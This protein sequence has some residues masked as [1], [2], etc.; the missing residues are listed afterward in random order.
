M[1]SEEEDTQYQI[2]D[3]DNL[4]D[5]PPEYDDYIQ[6]TLNVPPFPHRLYLNTRHPLT[7][8]INNETLCISYVLI[9]FALSIIL[10]ALMIMIYGT[11]IYL[12][13]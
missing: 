8:R 11:I 2:T 3:C 5:Q 9:I 6:S 7:S 13:Q 10:G 12:L 1:T 4:P